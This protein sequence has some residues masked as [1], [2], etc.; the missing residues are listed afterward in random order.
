MYFIKSYPGNQKS[1]WVCTAQ[2]IRFFFMKDFFSK[3]DQIRCFLQI[4][5]HLLNK[6]F[7]ENFIFCVVVSSSGV[8]NDAILV[9]EGGMF[10]SSIHWPKEG[11]V[12]DL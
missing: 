3:C 11:L 12:E 9:D 8:V 1:K 6:S 5:P 10:H 2:K 7:M 4:K